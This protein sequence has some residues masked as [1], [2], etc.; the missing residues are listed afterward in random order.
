VLIHY[1]KNKIIKE[2]VFKNRNTPLKL[3]QRHITI[4]ISIERE[5]YRREM[6]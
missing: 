3:P 6:K 5:A 1:G 4:G 2:K